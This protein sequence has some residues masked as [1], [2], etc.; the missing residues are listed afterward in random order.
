MSL[1][2]SGIVRKLSLVV[3]LVAILGPAGVLP[4]GGMQSGQNVGMPLSPGNNKALNLNVSLTGAGAT[5]PQPLIANWTT[6]YHRQYANTSITYSGIGS[7]G[8][9]NALWNKTTDFAAS[10]APLSPA[11]RYL[12]PNVLHIPETI[13]SVVL[14]YNLT[15][16]PSFADV[17]KGLNFT[18]N[19]IGKIYLGQVNLWDDPAIQ[20]L[21]P[22]TIFPHHN[23][24][25]VR[26]S[27]SSGTTFVFTGFLTLDNS[28]WASSIGQ[29]SV[30]TNWPGSTNGLNCG[31]N[32]FPLFL[33]G[34][35]NGN[36]AAKII[37]NSYTFGYVELNY[38]LKHNMTYAYVQN[39]ALK[40]IQPT[41]QTTKFAVEN[42][43]S[44]LP[45][46]GLSDW[47][48][49]NLLNAP[50]SQTYPIASFTYILVYQ[51]LNVYPR[52]NNNETS[53]A[54]ALI[55]F[56]RWAVHTGQTFSDGN[57]YVP[58]PS[59]V[60]AIDDAS[61][62]SIRLTI[63]SQSVHRTFHLTASSTGWN[64]TSNPSLSVFSNDTVTL[65]LSTSEATNHQFYIDSVNNHVLDNNESSTASPVF[66]S[67]SGTI[68]F[69]FTPTG[70]NS[71]SLPRFGVFTYRDSFN[72][73]VSAGSFTLLNQQA[74]G[75]FPSRGDIASKLLP[76]VDN[77]R[78]SLIGSL[79]IDFRTNLVSGNITV[80]AVDKNS[81]AVLPG[82]KWYVVANLPLLS[83]FILNVPASPY[84]LG[85]IA[86]ASTS[87][88]YTMRL[89]ELD[90]TG[91]G[92]IDISEL[93][94]CGSAV[95]GLVNTS[96]YNGKADVNADGTIDISDIV[97]I[98][99]N[100]GQIQAFH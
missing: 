27:D 23:I 43:T 25:T 16:I 7:G 84:D 11:Q 88:S 60:V 48:G 38:A 58:L 36:L 6:M 73:A 59:A 70:F 97:L 91:D 100:V 64:G 22:H 45:S 67:S 28:D 50:G 32:C 35:G 96:N 41:V 10:D 2:H 29:T 31:T 85:P 63:K 8:G 87:P 9:R 86:I 81:G 12:A 90:F 1:N 56:L 66:T 34:N 40:F 18:G 17:P 49:V 21:N 42:L 51:E 57:F 71:A 52:M 55:N 5:F 26:R 76:V 68:S 98:A 82:T 94:V 78:V 83:K 65:L 92:A 14:A 4:R 89:R 75:P 53:Q 33:T 3:I 24:T 44:V 47:S 37:N 72:P 99:S 95:G 80:V 79:I 15:K 20:A 77:T 74:A 46:S 19:L 62:N 69:T 54:S 39:P 61:I 13:G 93:A 30:T